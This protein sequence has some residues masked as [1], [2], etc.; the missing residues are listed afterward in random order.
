MMRFT[1]LPDDW[2]ILLQGVRSYSSQLSED[3]QNIRNPA[4]DGAPPLWSRNVRVYLDATFPDAWNCRSHIRHSL[5]DVILT[6]LLFAV[7]YAID[8]S[9]IDS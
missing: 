3:A 7:I 4:Q 8:R 5:T 6:D 9:V 1:L 2:P